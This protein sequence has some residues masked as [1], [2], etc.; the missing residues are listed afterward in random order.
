LRSA[1]YAG[2]SCLVAMA[3]GRDGVL[4]LMSADAQGS[5]KAPQSSSCPCSAF[6]PTGVRWEP[7][8]VDELLEDADVA[9]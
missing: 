6:R 4:K 7:P 1:H 5:P 9:A 8:P 2:G 3:V